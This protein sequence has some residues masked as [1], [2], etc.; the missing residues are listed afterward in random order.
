[1]LHDPQTQFAELLQQFVELFVELAFVW[2]QSAVSSD[3][4]IIMYDHDMSRVNQ[5]II[6]YNL[7]IS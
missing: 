2:T 6:M 7:D 1:M 3:I 4:N 5:D